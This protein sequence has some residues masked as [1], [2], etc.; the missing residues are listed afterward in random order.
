MCKLKSLLLAALTAGSFLF[1]VATTQAATPYKYC[2]IG[3]SRFV[4]MEQSVNTD[5][6]IVWVAK[7]G[8]NQGWYWENRDQIANMDRDTVIIFELGVNDFNAEG[9]LNALRDLEALGFKHIY[10]TS[11]TPV[12]EWKESQY[13]YSV[14][15]KRIEDFN[16][17]IRQNLPPSVA[18]MDGY[19]Y[20]TA[21]GVGT[22]DGVHYTANTYQNWLTNIMGSL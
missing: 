5:E 13:G 4:G 14:T 9:C 15:N 3:D 10:F 17:T 12:D 21:M 7:N 19:E 8:A 18:M 16:E 1:P 11:V 2:F 22:V 20:L 6:D